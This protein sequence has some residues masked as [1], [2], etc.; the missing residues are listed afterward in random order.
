MEFYSIEFQNENYNPIYHQIL[1]EEKFLK[2]S[3]QP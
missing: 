3:F 1:I 2:Y